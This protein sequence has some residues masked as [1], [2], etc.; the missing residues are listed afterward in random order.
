[1]S[2]SSV[3]NSL[4]P[5]LNPILNP[6]QEHAYALY[7]KASGLC[8]TT[9]KV[10]AFYIAGRLLQAAALASLAFS[11]VAFFVSAPIGVLGIITTIAMGVFGT[12]LVA[13]KQNQTDLEVPR[14]RLP[15]EPIG[16][17]NFGNDCWLNAG[18]Q[19]LAHAPALEQRVRSIPIIKQFFDAHRDPATQQQ[20]INSHRI[21]EY[22][23]REVGV[24]IDPGV[25]QEDA[26]VLF[27]TLFEG[28]NALYDF[29]Q[30]LDGQPGRPRKEP[31]IQFDLE[32]AET[33]PSFQQLF[34]RFFDYSDDL[35]QRHELFFKDQPSELLIHLKRFYQ[36]RSGERG[37]IDAPIEVPETVE[38]PAE[39]IHAGKKASYVID[40]FLVH[41]S[42]GKTDSS[43]HY[44]S[45][46]K[47]GGRWW[48]CSDS[49]VKQ[50]TKDQMKEA[51][52]T[53]YIL[54]FS[55]T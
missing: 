8:T 19:L 37:K 4:S 31:M 12:H 28:S 43:G 51:L 26:A 33:L 22:L 41:E 23:S 25:A 6:I 17:G 54:H 21:R 24:P 47:G 1:M 14:I 7:E 38:L 3:A 34:D 53:S 52:K 27:E 40:G 30:V 44:V 42:L 35:G 48:K 11:T 9:C 36:E 10:Q 55:K 16:F 20:K 49:T 18:L 15:G 46:I 2:T 32:K 13:A 29:D 50:V 45:Y 5:I 39:R